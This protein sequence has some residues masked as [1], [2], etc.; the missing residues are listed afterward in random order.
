MQVSVDIDDEKIERMIMRK[1]SETVG[2]DCTLR[3]H[4]NHRDIV[5]SEDVVPGPGLET[6][7][8]ADDLGRKLQV[9]AMAWGCGADLASE[10]FQV[11]GDRPIGTP[12][13]FA[14]VAPLDASKTYL[15]VIVE[16]PDEAICG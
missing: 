2:D 3:V 6:I 13:T 1:L 16:H 11:T 7:S 10:L 9:K 12:D 4:A 15:L 5:E 14:S 8:V